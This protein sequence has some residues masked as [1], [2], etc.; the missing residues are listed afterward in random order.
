MNFQDLKK[1]E[2]S[3]FYLDV[4]FSRASKRIDELRSSI[5]DK[6]KIKKSQLLEI[7]RLDIINNN[8]TENLKKIIK[9]YPSLDNLDPFYKELIKC[10]LDYKSLKNLLAQ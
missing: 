5:K 7:A 9:A 1:I 4:A 8:L 10:T 6:D 3:D 2:K